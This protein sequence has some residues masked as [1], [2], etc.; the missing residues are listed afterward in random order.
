MVKGIGFIIG[1]LIFAA[2]LYY[3]ITN[4]NDKES[5]KIYGITMAAGAIISIV[6]AVLLIL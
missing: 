3:F 6:A 5:R 1:I 2:G 4:K